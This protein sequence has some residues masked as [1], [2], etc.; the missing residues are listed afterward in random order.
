MSKDN[1]SKK[2]PI[3]LIIIAMLS[4]GYI[5]DNKEKS[6]TKTDVQN[7]QNYVQNFQN[8]HKSQIEQ[9]KKHILALGIKEVNNNTL[10]SI[11][12]ENDGYS[13]SLDIDTREKNIEQLGIKILKKIIESN[14]PFNII[15]CDVNIYNIGSSSSFAVFYNGES[16]YKFENGK[17]VDIN[18]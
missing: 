18:I 14:P 7:F 6:M 4:I 10:T 13:V 8:E 1:S 16:Y 17:A 9:L 2:M 12:A 11:T 5:C 3:I 15:E